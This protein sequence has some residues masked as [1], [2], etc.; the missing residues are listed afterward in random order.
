MLKSMTGFGDSRYEA[1]KFSFMVEVKTV[2][3][4]YLKVSV[5]LPDIFSFAETELEKIIKSRVCRGSVYCNIYVKDSGT[6]SVSDINHAAAMHYLDNFL[7]IARNANLDKT[8]P[9]LARLMLLPGVCQP[10][11]YSEDENKQ[12]MEVLAEQTQLALV[13]LNE[14][15]DHEGQALLNDLRK[16][17]DFIKVT[18]DKLEGMTHEVVNRYRDKLESRVNEL[19]AS[20]KLKLDEDTLLREVAVF[21]DKCDINEEISRLNAH[22]VQFAKICTDEEQVG[23]RLDF[24]TQEMLRE[25]NTIASKANNAQI[26]QHVVDIKVA[27]DRLR[28]QVQNVE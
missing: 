8:S 10:K 24:L 12:F 9:D 2:N 27:I 15:R 5:K 13:K 18:L 19:L 26:S 22:L 21:A 1:D 25:A 6:V 28:E 23:R 17:C 11:V 7:A 3:N 4:K 14:M 16:N 20:A